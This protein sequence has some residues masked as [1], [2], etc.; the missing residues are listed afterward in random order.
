M[1]QART[2][3]LE[4]DARIVQERQENAQVVQ[5]EKL[6]QEQDASM[7]PL[8]LTSAAVIKKFQ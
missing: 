1:E 2:A 3:H 5:V 7:L 4:M 6:F 8:Q